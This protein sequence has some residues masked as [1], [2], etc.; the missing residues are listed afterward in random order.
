MKFVALKMFI[1]PRVDVVDCTTGPLKQVARRGQATRLETSITHNTTL[2]HARP[3]YW[4][5]KYNLFLRIFNFLLLAFVLNEPL[6][7]FFP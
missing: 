4:D 2:T 7:F 1:I 5:F 3:V 6:S